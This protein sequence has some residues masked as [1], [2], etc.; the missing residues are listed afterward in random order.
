VHILVSHKKRI[1]MTLSPTI[2]K[3]YNAENLLQ[4]EILQQTRSQ[5]AK[6]FVAPGVLNTAKPLCQRGGESTE[7]PAGCQTICRFLTNNESRTS[8][9]VNTTIGAS[10]FGAR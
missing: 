8:S 5:G 1:D 9:C 6:L 2:Q 10:G 4:H 3:I 7:L